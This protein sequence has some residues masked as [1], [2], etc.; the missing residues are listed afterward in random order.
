MSWRGLQ[1]AVVETERQAD[2]VHWTVTLPGQKPQ[3]HGV[4]CTEQAQKTP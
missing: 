1:A 3:Q 2:R 4:W